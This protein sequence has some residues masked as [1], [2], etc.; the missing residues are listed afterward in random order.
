[1]Y[2]PI[3]HSNGETKCILSFDKWSKETPA[4]L[5]LKYLDLAKSQMMF[6]C[7]Q[8]HTASSQAIRGPTEVSVINK[9]RADVHGNITGGPLIAKFEAELQSY[10]LGVI[11]SNSFYNQLSTS[12][13]PKLASISDPKAWSIV[14]NVLMLISDPERRNAFHLRHLH[15]RPTFQTENCGCNGT[16]CWNCKR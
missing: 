14:K 5:G 11:D 6:T 10:T 1:M 13:I 8:C 3:E 4:S 7:S 9:A 12:L 16:H 2:C 15:T